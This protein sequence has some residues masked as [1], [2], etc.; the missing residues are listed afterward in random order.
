MF[1]YSLTIYVI[2]YWHTRI[3]GAQG[4]MVIVAVN[5]HGDTSSNLGRG[6]LHIT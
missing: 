2:L 1:H 6:R 4:A 3:K 5:A